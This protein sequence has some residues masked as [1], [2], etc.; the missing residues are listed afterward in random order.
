MS[1]ILDG[2]FTTPGTIAAPVAP[3]QFNL[4]LPSGYTEF[5]MVN[6][7][8]LVHNAATTQVMRASAYSLMNP[9]TA[10]RN[11]K[12]NGADSLAL[13]FEI[14]TGGFTFFDNA[15]P[16]VF[17][18]FAITGITAASPAVITTVGSPAWFVGDTIRLTGL[19]GTMQP[20]NGLTFT[21]D[22]VGGANTFTIT[23]DASGLVG[24]TPA[25]AGFG[26]K[27]IPNYFSPHNIV[28]GPTT[29]ALIA[30]GNLIQLPLNTVPYQILA[31]GTTVP[32]DQGASQYIPF[33][34]PYQPGA[35]LRLYMPTGFGTSAA[36]VNFITVKV[37]A[38]I[39]NAGGGYHFNN[40]LQ[41]Q[42][43]PG[44]PV[45]SV[46]TAAGLADINYPAGVANYRGQF[47]LV[48]DIA[49]VVQ[50]LSEA[51]DNTAIHGI[52][53][54]TGVLGDGAGGAFAPQTYQWFA[55]KGYSI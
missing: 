45:G 32:V 44:G 27:V 34:A 43:L 24:T 33:L 17:A 53:I 13:E 26:Q 11:L 6:V 7:T 4:S 9:G 35:I 49:E 50:D 25:T 1:S 20:M 2:F 5:R 29:T 42:I 21:I 18:T 8:P 47:P 15:N 16:P 23:F 52:T 46:T 37:I 3:A 55:R 10:F 39:Q 30:A 51:E 12:T 41:C 38:L 36:S 48:T 28:I 31:N 22:A 14:L 40:V 19:N 54:G